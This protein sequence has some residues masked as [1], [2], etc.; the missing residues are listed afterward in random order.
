MHDCFLSLY[1]LFV[2]LL[3]VEGQEAESSERPFG[4]TQVYWEEGCLAPKFGTETDRRSQAL[5]GVTQE[6]SARGRA[7]LKAAAGCRTKRTL[8]DRF[9]PKLGCL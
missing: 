8:L 1:I 9:D 5:I 2:N 6:N 4:H 7:S 3:L